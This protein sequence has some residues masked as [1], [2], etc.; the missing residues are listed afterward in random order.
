MMNTDKKLEFTLTTVTNKDS[1][2]VAEKIKQQWEKLGIK[3]NIQYIDQDSI[4]EDILK[5]R[6]YEILLYGE[7][8][9]GSSD[10]FPFWHS[11]QIKN[12]GLNLSLYNSKDVDQAIEKARKTTNKEET[13]D[14]Y[15]FVQEK[16]KYDMPAIF[17]YNPNYNYI[18]TENVHMTNDKEITAPSERFNNIQNWYIKTTKKLF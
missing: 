6:N 2:L 8:L 4:K 15:K 17:L 11:S 13:Q 1:Q 10:P 14:L 12:P 3:L 7:I 16:I 18:T 5:P 9:G